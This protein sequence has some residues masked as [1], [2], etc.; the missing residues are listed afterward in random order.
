MYIYIY[1]RNQSTSLCGCASRWKDQVGTTAP[2]GRKASVTPLHFENMYDDVS[3]SQ[4]CALGWSDR[5]SYPRQFLTL[6]LCTVPRSSLMDPSSRTPAT[7]VVHLA[8]PRRAACLR[9]VKCRFLCYLCS[10]SI[11]RGPSALSS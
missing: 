6:L 4:I 5:A 11:G 3:T 9:K 8:G 10:S 2:I 7:V 1:F